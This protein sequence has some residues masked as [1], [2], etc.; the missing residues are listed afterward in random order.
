MKPEMPKNKKYMSDAEIEIE[1]ITVLEKH[2][3]NRIQ[4]LRKKGAPEAMIKRVKLDL[5]QLID[6]KAGLC[7][8]LPEWQGTLYALTSKRGTEGCP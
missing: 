6:R 3:C 5:V 4:E 1:H 7:Q 8:K 2:A